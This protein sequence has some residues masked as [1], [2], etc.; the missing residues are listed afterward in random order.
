ML[1]F[2]VRGPN[3]FDFFEFDDCQRQLIKNAKKEN[4][5]K[6]VSDKLR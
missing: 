3:T 4:K 6:R 1:V 5:E 2:R